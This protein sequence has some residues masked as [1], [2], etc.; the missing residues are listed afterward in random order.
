MTF[1]LENCGKTYIYMI[2]KVN[3][4][5]H[6]NYYGLFEISDLDN[7]EINPRIESVSRIQPEMKEVM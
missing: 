4:Q 1:N 6:T 3:R 2:L 5:G 7:V